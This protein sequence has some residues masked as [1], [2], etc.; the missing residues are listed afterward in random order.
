MTCSAF[1][2]AHGQR[3]FAYDRP[4]DP[5]GYGGSRRPRES[6]FRAGRKGVRNRSA[7]FPGSVDGAAGSFEVAHVTC[8][9]GS[10]AH[11]LACSATG[12]RQSPCCFLRIFNNRFEEVRRFVRLNGDLRLLPAVLVFLSAGGSATAQTIGPVLSQ[13]PATAGDDLRATSTLS[14]RALQELNGGHEAVV[15]AP[16]ADAIP[17]T[18]RDATARGYSRSYVIGASGAAVTVADAQRKAAIGALL[19]QLDV[20]YAYGVERSSPASI[21]DSETGQI[22]AVDTH[23]RQ[24]LIITL[25]QSLFDLSAVTNAVRTRHLRTAARAV[26]Q[27]DQEDEGLRVA[28]AYFTLAQASLA[29]S[30]LN[31]HVERLTT[32]DRWMASRVAG[33]GASV[34]DG[35]QVH[36]RVLAA[37]SLVEQQKAVRDQALI[38]FEELTG[39]RPETIEIPTQMANS[40]PGS[41]DEALEVAFIRSPALAQ[42]R[43]QERAADS[44][45]LSALS[46][47]LPR[48]SA[49]V[50]QVGAKNAGG[51][52][53]WRRDRRA[54]LVATWSLR[55][56]V[57]SQNARAAAAR[58]QQYMFQRLD[59]ERTVTQA[60]RVAFAALGTVRARLDATRKE[61]TA[62]TEVAQS[63]DE[64]F[65]AGRKSLLEVLDAYDRLYQSRIKMLEAG[66]SGTL[67]YFQTLRV[68]GEL[69]ASLSTIPAE[70]N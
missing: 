9:V 38:A 52:P 47:F 44:E 43:A 30:L 37:D 60:L 28:Q 27:G 3:N 36:A 70:G 21:V 41:L 4:T 14:L 32:L 24:D 48:L 35:Q 34:S 18:L 64:Q 26:A 33:G 59:Q 20:R 57:T 40:A 17:T 5:S 23:R 69:R 19:P 2:A 42:L 10:S 66:I 22:V 51:D 63:F 16:S 11:S 15:I 65:T 49:E 45:R 62:N 31:Q 13:A 6:A 50:S 54:M 67:L 46:G 12:F 56:L 25:S 39:L 8:R 53:G 7:G 1:L 61:M 55:P 68:T 58:E 29:M